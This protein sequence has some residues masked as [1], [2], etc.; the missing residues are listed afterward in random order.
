MSDITIEQAYEKMQAACGIGN[1]DE[2]KLLR[3]YETHEM[4]CSLNVVDQRA[5]KVGNNYFA[6][7]E[8]STHNIRLRDNLGNCVGFAPFFCLELVEKAES[9]P[10][11]IMVGGNAVEFHDGHITVGCERIS[12]GT[13]R[14]ILKRVE[15][16]N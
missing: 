5:I 2:V 8:Y 14:A 1:K 11:P 10:P 12:H 13:V 7:I 6:E 4:G 15:E 3:M 16:K 9:E